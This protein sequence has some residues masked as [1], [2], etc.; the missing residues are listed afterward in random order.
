MV[1]S[2][3]LLKNEK[4]KG[5]PFVPGKRLVVVGSDV[6]S[7]AAIMEPGNYN[8][9]NICPHGHPA[10]GKVG[11]RT[12]IDTSCL[13]SIWQT[14]NTTNAKAGGTT[15]LLDRSSRRRRR[16]LRSGGGG[17]S[18]KWDNASIAQAVS[19]IRL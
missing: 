12:G 3:I 14:L 13:S 5:L 19:P 15:E 6:D 2:M 16:Q 7:L 4:G 11:V 8:A 9:D 10:A 18:A 1:Q 17:A